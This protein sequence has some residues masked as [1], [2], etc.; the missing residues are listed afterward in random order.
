MIKQCC[1]TFR[2]DGRP[3]IGYWLGKQYWGK[4]IATRAL[5]AFVKQL[6]ERPLYAHVVKHNIG[7]LRV[8]EK[9]GF[10]IT[11]EGIDLRLD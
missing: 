11:G 1:A 2:Q 3:E 6:P 9:N 8:L 10:V 7:L 4:G 5:A